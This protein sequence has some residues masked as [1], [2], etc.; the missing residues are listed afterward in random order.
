MITLN[1]K[2]GDDA[3]YDVICKS[4]RRKTMEWVRVDWTTDKNICNVIQ[5][6]STNASI[7]SKYMYMYILCIRFNA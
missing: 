4:I 6:S 2:L 3:H 7:I 1:L 5:S